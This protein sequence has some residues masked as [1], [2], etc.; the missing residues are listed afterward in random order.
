MPRNSS[1]Q[2]DRKEAYALIGAE[3]SAQA[4]REHLMDHQY[5]IKCRVVKDPALSSVNGG[6]QFRTQQWTRTSWRAAKA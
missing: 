2:R 5:A 1:K 4:W 6:P 3:I